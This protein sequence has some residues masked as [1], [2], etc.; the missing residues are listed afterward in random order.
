[1]VKHKGMTAASG[2]IDIPFHMLLDQIPIHHG[3]LFILLV[4]PVAHT[5]LYMSLTE[6]KLLSLF[7]EKGKHLWAAFLSK[8]LIFPLIK[9]VLISG[10]SYITV[11]I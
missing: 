3:V 11:E 5:N 8:T 9:L 6:E 10:N 2:N 4:F 1:M 7:L